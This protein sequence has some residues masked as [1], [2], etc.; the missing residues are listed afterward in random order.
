[1]IIIGQ[2]SSNKDINQEEATSSDRITNRKCEDSS[3]EIE[4][5]ET[6]EDGGQA[7]VNNI[8]ELNLGTTKEPQP[9]YVS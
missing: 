6:L 7:T 2:L 4:L 5:V 1:V 9:I 8:K 3:V